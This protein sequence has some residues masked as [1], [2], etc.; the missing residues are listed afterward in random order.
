MNRE[1]DTDRDMVTDRDRDTNIDMVMGPKK[2][3]ADRKFIYR[4]MIPRRNLLRG[5]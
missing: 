2:N 4:G 5:V 3:Y 1:T